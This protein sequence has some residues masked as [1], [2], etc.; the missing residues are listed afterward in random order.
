MLLSSLSVC[1][2]V[3]LV[4]CIQTAEAIIKLI[5]PPSSLIILIFDCKRWY[6]IPRGTV[7]FGALNTRKCKKL[8]IFDWNHHFSWKRCERC[9][10][11]TLKRSQV[12]DRSVSVPLTLSDLERRDTKVIFQSDLLNNAR[13]YRLTLERQH[14]AE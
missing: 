5:S 1:L 8:V 14:S 3:T 9:C 11:R 12:A 7:S 2:S 4:Y 13:T 6:P 10:Y